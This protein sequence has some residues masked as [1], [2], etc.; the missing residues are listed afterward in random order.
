MHIFKLKIDLGL[1][2]Q[3]FFLDSWCQGAKGRRRHFPGLLT[4][5]R[6]PL[7]MWGL[8]GGKRPCSPPRRIGSWR[9]TPSCSG[10]SSS[11]WPSPSQS[12]P[13]WWTK[14]SGPFGWGPRAATSS[15]WTL[16]RPQG[17]SRCRLLV[18]RMPRGC[19]KNMDKGKTKNFMMAFSKVYNRFPYVLE[20]PHSQSLQM[21]GVWLLE[22]LKALFSCGTCQV[23]KPFGQFAHLPLLLHLTLLW[24]WPTSSFGLMIPNS[25]KGGGGRSLALCSR[26]CPN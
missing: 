14:Q 22:T 2:I 9:C 1:K 26:K 21:G 17:P 24:V 10:T 6:W 20:W 7:S 8:E 23:V 4:P 13:S 5:S 11:L 12:A 15:K 19:L 3:R 18:R 25:L 16:L